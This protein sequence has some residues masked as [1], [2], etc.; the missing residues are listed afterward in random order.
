METLKA[1]RKDDAYE[2][3]ANSTETEDHSREE[4]TETQRE[5]LLRTTR[6]A[7]DMD[8]RLQRFESLVGVLSKLTVLLA[9]MLITLITVMVFQ[10]L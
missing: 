1:Y 5:L 10:Y 9:L 8:Q 3:G 6:Q 2:A 4:F 7:Q